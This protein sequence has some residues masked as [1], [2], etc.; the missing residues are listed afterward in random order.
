[1]GNFEVKNVFLVDILLL[2]R[3]FPVFPKFLSLE[4]VFLALDP[5][6]QRILESCC[7]LGNVPLHLH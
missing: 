5:F 3:Y 4:H 6:A 1:M 2:D 7:L